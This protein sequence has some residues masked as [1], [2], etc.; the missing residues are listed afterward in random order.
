MELGID[1]A[2]Q[3][4]I[5]AHKAGD[6]NEADKFYTAIL[7]VQPQHPDANHNMGVLAVSIGKVREALPYFKVALEANPAI[8]QFWLSYIDALIRE[9]QF[10]DA[11]PVIEQAKKQGVTK[12][13]LNALTE[14]L[15]TDGDT[16]VPSEAQQQSLLNCFQGK[17]YEKAE[18]LAL[19]LTQDYPYH[20]FGWKVLG[21]VLNETGRHADALTANQ[22]AVEVNPGDAEAHNNLGLTLRELNRLEEA[23]RSFQFSI[24]LKP[25]YP[26]PLNNIGLV[27]NAF[28]QPSR[29]QLYF[30]RLLKIKPVFSKAYYNFAISWLMQENQRGALIQ[31]RRGVLLN[32]DDTEIYANL[33]IT[34]QK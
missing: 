31:F 13:K 29:A 33:G 17:H 16:A 3:R 2:L 25:F 34:H 28:K 1:E 12:E 27:F 6:L 11:R 21:A 24:L 5:G 32:P 30:S 14:R 9:Q 8:E 4:G 20:S 23:E 15:P 22:K 19:S 18:Q 10:T 7:K 26:E